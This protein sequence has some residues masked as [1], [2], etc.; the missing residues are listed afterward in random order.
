GAVL[1]VE[2]LTCGRA[3]APERDLTL[4]ALARLDH[5]PDERGDDVRRLEVEVVARSV[6]VHREQIHGVEAVLFSVALRAD[7]ERFLRHAVRGGRLLRVAVPEL[8]L[9]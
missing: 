6:E 8:V 9:A 2:E 4:A 1:D 7:E 5:L 3:V